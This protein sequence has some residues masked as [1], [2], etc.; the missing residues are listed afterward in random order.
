MGENA[1]VVRYD[2]VS[3]ENSSVKIAKME[4]AID[5]SRVHAPK[6]TVK[7]LE[8]APSVVDWRVVWVIEPAHGALINLPGIQS[9][10]PLGV[11][12]GAVISAP[13]QSVSLRVEDSLT[14]GEFRADWSD[15][16]E[17]SLSVRALDSGHAL[18]VTFSAGKAYIDP[19][20]VATTS[21]TSPTD[22]SCQRKVV[23]YDGYYW[24][25]YDRGDTICYKRSADGQSWS[26]EYAL[27]EGTA[28]AAGLGFDVY[29]R[30]GK[31]GVGWIDSAKTNTY[32]K[33]GT[34][35]GSK[36]QWNARSFVVQ[37]LGA[38]FAPVSVTIGT[39]GAYDV[40]VQWRMIPGYYCWS[41]FRSFDGLAPWTS[42]GPALNYAYSNSNTWNVILPFGNGDL[43]LLETSQDY[44]NVRVRYWLSEYGVSSGWT[45]PTEYT[46][47]MASGAKGDKFSAIIA[48]D[49]VIHIAMKDTSS[50]L[51]YAYIH[52]SGTMS[53]LGLTATAI[54]GYPSIS[55][56]ENNDLHIF[57]LDSST[58]IRHIQKTGPYIDAW[59][60]IDTFYTSGTAMKGLTSWVNPVGTHTLVWTALTTPY[61]VM[62][63]SIPLPYGT[64]GAAAEPWNRD[65][66]SPYGTYFSTF[67]DYLSPGSG[68]LTLLETDA[69]IPGRGVDL[70]ISRIYQQPRYF[71]TSDGQP[72]MS[73]AYPYSDLGPG[74]SLD[75]PWMD[76]NYVYTGNGQRF[77]IQWGNN[78]NDHEFENHDDVHFVLRDVTKIAHGRAF[79]YFELI[80]ASGMRYS[81]DHGDYR[82][83]DFGDLRGYDPEARD[84]TPSY[85]MITVYYD[86]VNNRITSLEEYDLGRAITFAY[87]ANGMLQT[88]TR[89][90][91]ETI[92]F[93]YTSIG[94]KYM[95]TS[96]TDPKSRVTTFAY[97][98]YGSYP[99][100]Y[101]LTSIQFPTGAKNMYT[102]A[103]DSSVGTEV[104]AWLVT[105]QKVVDAAT[106]ARIRQTDYDYKVVSGKVRF[107][108]ATD[109]NEAGV[110]QGR[111]ESVFVSDLKYSSQTSKDASGVQ[112]SKKVTW[113]DQAGQPMRVDTYK[114]S[115]QSINYS[116]YASYDDWGNV[117]FSKNA[118]GYESYNSYANTKTQNSFQGG[119]LLK[120]TTSGKIFYDS[121]DDWDIS[122]WSRYTENAWIGLV[123]TFDAPNAPALALGRGDAPS[124]CVAYHTIPAQSADFVMQLSW[125]T[126][127]FE[128]SY[129]LGRSGTTSR[130][131]FSGASGSFQYYNSSSGSWVAVG[132]YVYYTWYDIGF[133]VHFS[134]NKYDIYVDGVL[135][136]RGA[137]LI[138]SG[139]IDS[140]RFQEGDAGQ[141]GA[142][143]VIDSIR[144]YKSLSVTVSMGSGY[145]AELYDAEGKLLDRS[146]TGTLSVAALPLQFPPGYIQV[147]KIGDYSFQTPIMDIWGGD[148]Y[149]MSVGERSSSLPKSAIGFGRAW[150]ELADDAWPVGST[151][152]DSS[153]DCTWVD[154]A[155][156]AV[157]GTKYH[158]SRY[159][160]GSHYHGFLNG[161]SMQVWSSY[162]L[163][164][165][166]WLTEGRMPSEIMV[167]YYVGGVWKRAYW[168]GGGGGEDL[169][170]VPGYTPTLTTR[171]G[172]LP[173]VTGEWL[174]LTVT[175]ADLGIT[176]TQ[177][178]SGVIFGL[179]GGTA[180]WDWTSVFSQGIYVYGL[181]PSQTVELWFDSG[182]FASASSPTQPALLFPYGAGVKTFPSSGYFRIMEGTKLVYASPWIPEIWNLDEYSFSAPKW[183]ADEIK[184]D[185]GIKG[186]I[187]DR[188][189]GSFNYQDVAKTV[190]QEM[191]IRHSPEGDANETK[192]RLGAGWVYSRADYDMYGNQIWSSD[193]TG[194]GV[195]TLYSDTDSRTYPVESFK[196]GPVGDSFE[197]DTSWTPS[198]SGSGGYTYWMDASYTTLRS[199]S[200][201]NSV[202]LNFSNGPMGY[203]TCV[204]TMWKEYSVGKVFDLSLWTYLETYSHEGTPGDTMDSG[205]KMR[206]Y[207]S[208][209]TNYATYTYWL[210]CWSGSTDNKTTADPNVK[211]IWGK[212]TMGTWLNPTLRPQTDWPSADWSRCAKVKLELY[213][214][215]S[216]AYGDYFKVYYD[217]LSCY[218]R[219]TFT[220]EQNTGRLLS[221]TDA[222]GRITSCLY[223]ELGRPTK[224]TNPDGTFT[225]T[226]YDDVNNKATVLDELN[227]KTISYFDKIARLTKVERYGSGSTVYSD[228]H[229]T[230]NW[231]DMVASFTD[232]RGHVTTYAYDYLGRQTRVTNPDSTY[233][234]VTYDDTNVTYCSYTSGNVLTHKT[235]MV[236]DEVGRLNATKEHTTSTAY[237]QT[238]MA[239]DAAGSVLT[240]KD[241][242]GQVTRM[243]YDSLTRLTRTTYPDSLYESATYDEAGRTL[244][245]TDR[246]GN[247]TSSSYDSAG[248]LVR[249]ASPSDT[250]SRSYDAA[251]QLLQLKSNLG[252][253]SYAYNARGWVKSLTEVIGSNSY[254]VRLG[255]DTEGKQTWVLY[256]SGLN[257]SYGYDS[258]DR[259]TTVTK[260]PST[261]LLIITYNLDDTIASETTGD[262]TKVTT[263]AYNSRDW[264]TGI[265]MKLSG[266]IKLVLLYSYDDVG[267][268]KQLVVNTT[269][270]ASTAKT[271]TYSYD[272]LDRLRSANGGSLPSGLTYG[273]DAV[274]NRISKGSITYTYGSY[275]QLTGDGTWSY[276]YDGNGNL[277][278]KTKSAEKWNYQFNS[279]DQLTKVVK[280]TKSGQT[281][282]WTTQGEYWYDA[283]GAMAKSVEGTTTTEYVYRGHDPLCEKNTGTGVFTDYVYVNGRMVAKQTG[284]DIDYYIKDALG[285]TRLVYRDTSQVFSV[286]TYAPFGT[287]VT[288]S[289][290][291]KFKYAGEMLVGAAGSSPGLYYIGARWMDPELGRFISL[292][293]QLGSLSSP[294]TMNRYVYCV[295]NPLRFTDPTGQ[296][297]WVAIG[298]AV[299]AIVSTAIYLATTDNPTLEGALL[300]AASGAVT[301]AVAAATFG[302][303]TLAGRTI[304][305]AV[306]GGVSMAVYAG[307]QIAA[308]QKITAQGLA[309]AGAGGF[310]A[311]FIGGGKQVSSLLSIKSLGAKASTFAWQKAGIRLLGSEAMLAGIGA[312]F[313]IKG[314]LGVTGAL[315]G[316]GVS[317]ATGDPNKPGM[318]DKTLGWSYVGSGLGG[319][320]S[321]PWAGAPMGGTRAS[322]EAGAWQLIG[323]FVKVLGTLPTYR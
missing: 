225:T 83:T 183:Y 1:L 159:T 218:E 213:V 186:F 94:G 60:A 103:Q 124:T 145:V 298:A 90:D 167:Q 289:G 172:A 52:P 39:D 31:I 153:S 268:V 53:S 128:R 45:N 26:S 5:F 243:T 105:Q 255:Y 193:P 106:S 203:D 220:Y 274:G 279:L 79:Q 269:Y 33:A 293:P 59:S 18:Q 77:I 229:Y 62:F 76:R 96:V 30:D 285:S 312:R 271:E 226:T 120:R 140:I 147:S 16:K 36:I 297:F 136:K 185:G 111:T 259:V 270:K 247:I 87:N 317:M 84:Y 276:S 176:S 137:T 308:G 68:L 189:V 38:C 275:N 78:G 40:F 11:F 175:A 300:A 61:S 309:A 242:K 169:I 222:L 237:N 55:L 248:N 291:E 162:V 46:V 91:T 8:I 50:Y 296:W 93:G 97:T 303:G 23:W 4:A 206:L 141:G 249:I 319:L 164:Q 114:G 211:V 215:A 177:Y 207:D 261:T 283:N 117:V 299:G 149:T 282:T 264:V 134:A 28:L 234:T 21:S 144:L 7:V 318:S 44:T 101:L 49:G 280:G 112:L 239:Y 135:A 118:M 202:K 233:G 294:Q 133:V 75:L 139:A 201:S 155:D 148:S 217:D 100:N 130:L 273:Y 85:N 142:T 174:Q 67:M 223:D 2:I 13:D 27:P 181:T 228:V 292:D 305:G 65:G 284:S 302:V 126:S 182:Q 156:Y 301:G 54:Y 163:L 212:P 307:A 154:D 66:L 250:I 191:Y 108:N 205:I 254:Q 173:E 263:Y 192:V 119:S 187:H 20:L 73:F 198:L 227:H 236:M 165:Y 278:W 314:A 146:K 138:G 322:V 313:A 231:Q 58:V 113:Y 208:A 260:L 304:S 323:G 57:W 86:Y 230:Y 131:N 265:N 64:P 170:N 72:Y 221:S 102:Y 253:I 267:N 190:P 315:V 63:G 195:V 10:A 161:D 258:Y 88:I 184:T 82:I 15:E 143:T 132:S 216:W 24:V 320:G 56:D 14:P 107:V 25:F 199:H 99:Y 69:S 125:W 210:A 188:Q 12:N 158:E 171:V 219:T 214:Y 98:S 19:T 80:M 209:G 74:W 238:L 241:A 240:V 160:E 197:A 6:I 232:E 22:L 224:V 95:L 35:L 257:V 251:G 37:G 272:W 89:P 178:C 316:A 286:A 109:S 152:I 290:T 306:S 34:F 287:P 295:N 200:S 252:T 194:R 151:I 71:R 115:S 266:T 168:G 204:A 179:F 41:V 51:K 9:S 42:I 47:G 29:A 129:V 32:F 244:T 262:G 110:V 92:T 235:V 311:G 245:K 70:S 246:E 288:P 127:S 321:D 48:L 196:A 43:A 281:W 121:F 310:V 17:G 116:E 180:K 122:D 150:G 81:F 104:R 157:S 123:A 256:P 166:V 3:P 277:A